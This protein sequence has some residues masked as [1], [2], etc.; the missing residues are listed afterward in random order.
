MTLEIIIEFGLN[1]SYIQYL[2][3]TP[4]PDDRSKVKKKNYTQTQ[5]RP[6]S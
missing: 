4:K 5:T 3:F 6:K 2:D 1:A